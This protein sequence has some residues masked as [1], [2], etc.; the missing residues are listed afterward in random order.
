[1]F[2]CEACKQEYQPWSLAFKD[3][4]GVK[5]ICRTC[6]SQRKQS[7][8]VINSNRKKQNDLSAL[9]SRIYRIEQK[10]ENVSFLIESSIKSEAEM[11]DWQTIIT[12]IIEKMVEQRWS[13][14]EKEI[15]SMQN[16]LLTMHTRMKN[17]V[18]KRIWG[19]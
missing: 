8:A 14:M 10:Q 19:D 5:A 4:Q 11:I 13:K 6:D 16:Q 3:R 7:R 9:E 15:R 1:M 17:L 18:E 2:T 12:P